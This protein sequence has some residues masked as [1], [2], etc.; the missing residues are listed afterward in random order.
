MNNIPLEIVLH[1]DFI[2][3]L[4]LQLQYPQTIYDSESLQGVLKKCFWHPPLNSTWF[5]SISDL[6]NQKK[7][8]MFK[9]WGTGL[10][11]SFNI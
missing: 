11:Y 5:T 8:L 7:K 10:Y 1:F 3:K 9:K 4:D 2:F 6:K